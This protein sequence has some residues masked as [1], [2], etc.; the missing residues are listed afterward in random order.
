MVWVVALLPWRMVVPFVAVV[1]VMP[2]TVIMTVVP[3]VV[4]MRMIM[5][6]IVMMFMLVT[7]RMIMLVVVIMLVIVVMAMLTPM[8]SLVVF[9]ALVVVVA[10]ATVGMLV[11]VFGSVLA[12]FCRGDNVATV[13]AFRVEVCEQALCVSTKQSLQVH[14]HGC[15]HPNSDLRHAHVTATVTAMTVNQQ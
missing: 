7:V 1:M 14:L 10:T 11:A 12:G 6:V 2:M 13:L 9:M 8:R 4:A 3:M 5:L 15:M